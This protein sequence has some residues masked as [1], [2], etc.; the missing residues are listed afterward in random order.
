MHLHL[1]RPRQRSG[2]N[3]LV[4]WLA[5]LSSDAAAEPFIGQFE[6]KTLDSAAGMFEL[7]SQNAWSWHAPRRAYSSTADG[8]LVFD[9]NS[10]FRSRYALEVE[11]G[12][13][14]RL[15]M[16]VG[17]E[18]EQERLAA[19]AS[20]AQ[21]DA[22]GSLEV[23]EFGAEMVVVFV[24]RTGD[25]VGIGAVIE[26]EGP[27]DQE[28]PNHL[29]VGAI[30]EYTRSAWT[31][32]GVPM[33]VHSFGGDVEPGT[34]RDEKIDFAYATQ[35]IRS[36]SDDW[37]IAVEAYGTVERI[38][39]TG[40]P[41]LAQTRFGDSNQHRLGLVAYYE[42]TLFERSE[43]TLGLGLL[44]GLNSNTPDHTLKLSIELDF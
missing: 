30:V 39:D 25:G 20:L 1:L 18:A 7:Q 38:G 28:E 40:T 44:E 43:I 24:P 22:F 17:I 13:S 34:R 33:L 10:I 32:V 12:F 26:I 37:S 3:A 2:L 23:E 41:S 6:V 29:T 36:L 8:E 14:E 16:R 19:P 15:K 9:D 11:F 4:G 42:R 31:W 21:A 27:F 5:W 35:L